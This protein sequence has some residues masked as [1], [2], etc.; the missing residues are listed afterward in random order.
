MQYFFSFQMNECEWEIHQIF[1]VFLEYFTMI[2]YTYIIV[3]FFNWQLFVK[4]H[5]ILYSLLYKTQ[6][7]HMFLQSVYTQLVF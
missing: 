1:F 2:Y 7:F 5:V 4:L 3:L 6:F